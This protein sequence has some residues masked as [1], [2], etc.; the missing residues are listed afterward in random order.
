ME[1]YS[2][3]TKKTN[4][5]I[6]D[7]MP[8]KPKTKKP[9]KPTQGK[10]RGK[11]KANT[12]S[13]SYS[14]NPN[15]RQLS[16]EESMRMKTPTQSTKKS[17]TYPN[18]PQE[19]K[20]IKIISWNINGIRSTLR[21]KGENELQKLIREEDPD[22]ICFNETKVDPTVINKEKL[23]D[24]F[25]DT[26]KSIWHCAE[27]KK[28]YSGTAIFSKYEPTGIFKGIQNVEEDNEGRVLRIEFNQFILVSCYT[29]NSGS[30]L[31]R[32]DF[33]VNNWDQSF[34]KFMNS[35][36]E[37]NKNI[38]LCG[39]LNVVHKDLDNAYVKNTEAVAGL[40]KRERD[41]F[42]SFLEMGFRDTFRDTHPNERKYSWFSPFALENKTE[43]KGLRIDYFITGNEF[44]YQI[45]KTDMLDK[46]NYISS[47]HIP[48]VF[49]FEI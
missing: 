45:T 48:I 16:I 2:K 39:D 28:G 36:K 21:E 11:S 49:E 29:P 9:A 23:E 24:L 7:D 31:D 40:T 3:P 5:H 17:K 10:K 27:G 42:T 4:P 43:N 19:H 32:L 25:K 46:D 1:K 22:F 41:S 12:Q 14:S 37:R 47:D 26:Y 34:F 13:S 38:I 35:L 20:K 33:R 18:L 15:V 6:T 44:E 30:K 8:D